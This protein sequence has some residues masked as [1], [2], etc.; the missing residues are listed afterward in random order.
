MRRRF[1]IELQARC[2]FNLDIAGMVHVAARF[3][4]L[5]YRNLLRDDIVHI[6]EEAVF[7]AGVQFDG[8]EDI[9]E[10]EAV[11]NDAGVV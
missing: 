2:D 10:L 6:V 3:Q 4:H 9:S 11:D 5:L 8:A 1:R 7:L